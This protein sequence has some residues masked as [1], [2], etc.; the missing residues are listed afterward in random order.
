MS[1][2]QKTAL[3]QNKSSQLIK[4]VLVW[5]SLM[6]LTG[7]AGS[8]MTV[9]V[10]SKE[11]DAIILNVT[12]DETWSSAYLTQAGARA[13]M[14]DKITSAGTGQSTTGAQQSAV[15]EA[16]S[17]Q[18]RTHAECLLIG[19]RNT[20]VND[21]RSQVH[22]VP[23][24]HSRCFPTDHSGQLVVPQ[25]SPAAAT[26]STKLVY[27]PPVPPPG[28]WS[29]ANMA[30]PMSYLSDH[31]A[32][33]AAAAAKAAAAAAE[34]AADAKAAAAEATA[35]KATATTTTAATAVA[36]VDVPS[37]Q[38]EAFK[39]AVLGSTADSTPVT[40][41]KGKAKMKPAAPAKTTVEASSDTGSSTSTTAP[42]STDVAPKQDA[43]ELAPV[44][45]A[46]KVT[47]GPDAKAAVGTAAT[48]DTAV[49][50]KIK[51]AVAPTSTE[52]ATAT[53]TTA[54]ATTDV[55]T[56]TGTD[57]VTAAACEKEASGCGMKRAAET[58][59]ADT[60]VAKQQCVESTS[61]SVDAN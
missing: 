43:V 47:E 26:S 2:G 21:G 10:E 53:A 51:S 60:P 20:Q 49:K 40:K 41:V 22:C 38:E 57:T 25:P 39:P 54:T 55:A 15:D 23:L 1:K 44:K 61:S 29:L 11:T 58:N 4:L 59:D 36:V 33:C 46:D 37:P 5:T 34:A 24:L 30:P 12:L 3:S 48:V 45:V 16:S 6:Q 13:T 17:Q 52:P 7:K 42:T 56:I 35:V 31:K 19:V 18:V 32:V 9:V 50:I 14:V 28:G 27:V 8:S